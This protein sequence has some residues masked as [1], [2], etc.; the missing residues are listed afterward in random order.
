VDACA[1]VLPL[2][3]RRGLR[4]N[5]VD[6]FER[7]PLRILLQY[8]AWQGAA[9]LCR[10]GARFTAADLAAL[11]KTSEGSRPEDATAVEELLLHAAAAAS[12]ARAGAGGGAAASAAGA[13]AARFAGRGRR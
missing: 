9:L 3:L 4:V 13:S 2:L 11:P 12:A 6:A 5:A 7:A 1:A 8:G 10:H